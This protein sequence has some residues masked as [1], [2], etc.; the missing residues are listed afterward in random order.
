LDNPPVTADLDTPPAIKEILRKACYDCHSNETQLK[1]FDKVA[2]AYWMVADHVKKGRKVLNFSEM[3]NLSIGD[4]KAKL[5][6]G[7]NQVLTGD[8]PLSSYQLVHSKAKLS[9]NDASTLQR[10]LVSLS[11]TVIADTARIHAAN[12]QYDQWMQQQTHLTTAKP[13]LNGIDYIPGYQDWVAVS[14]TDRFD[15]GTMRVI[16]G[17]DIAAK[18]I[19]E[20]KIHPWPDGTIF[21][22]VA[23]DQLADTSGQI[24]PGEFKQ[25]EFMIKDSKKYAATAG[26]GW[27]RWKGMQLAPYG[28]TAS[29][30]A[31][32][33]G[34]HNPMRD[35]D[36][37]FTLPLP[38][39][40]AT[41]PHELLQNINEWKVISTIVDRTRKT[42]S[43]LYGNEVAARKAGSGGSTYP[44]GSNLCLVTWQQQDDQHW[45]GGRI[46][47]NTQSVEFVHFNDTDT[48][49]VY[50]RYEGKPLQKNTSGDAAFTN[51]RIHFIVSRKMLVIP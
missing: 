17:N 7:F 51:E 39:N 43:V 34:C 49:P 44:S 8:M 27:A 18:A 29:F 2:P 38:N 36:F 3:G 28:K 32:C 12:R 16:Y 19:K 31:E 1:W 40:A 5:Y 41:L 23:W 48:R 30:T 10:Y 35:N 24:T 50:E 47:G 22:K 4:Q 33:V 37:V 42:M 25:V 45:F 46:P 26:W 14:T 15:N 21:A 9:Q 6:E 11:P 13:T 20:Q